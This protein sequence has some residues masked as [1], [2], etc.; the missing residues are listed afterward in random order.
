VTGTLFTQV[1]PFYDAAVV[2]LYGAFERGLYDGLSSG[3]VRRV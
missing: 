2:R 1:L 3:R